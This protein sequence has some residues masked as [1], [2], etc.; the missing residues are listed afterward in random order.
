MKYL[1]FKSVIQLYLF[2]NSY[3]AFKRLNESPLGQAVEGVLNSLK[4]SKV[5]KELHSKGKNA[6]KYL[7][8]KQL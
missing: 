2:L 5:V 7:T 1:L 3:Q 4:S 8:D 6:D